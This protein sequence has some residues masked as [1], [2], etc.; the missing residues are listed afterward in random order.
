MHL[1]CDAG[2]RLH[3]Q[4]C[5]LVLYNARGTTAADAVWNTATYIGDPNCK[6]VVKP[7]TTAATDTNLLQ[8][9]DSKNNV[10]WSAPTTPYT[11][12]GGPPPYYPS[13]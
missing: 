9:L 10:L 1:G 2:A 6:L 5:N 4:D 8:V 11:P 7:L 12:P 3:A 13:G